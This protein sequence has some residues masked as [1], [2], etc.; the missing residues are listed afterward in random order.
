MIAE[1][2]FHRPADFVGF[3]AE[4]GI[5]ER[6]DHHAARKTSQAATLCSGPRILR[7]GSRQFGETLRRLLQDLN[8]LG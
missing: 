5:L 3:H 6:L 7:L 8:Q 4:H 2:A 1:I